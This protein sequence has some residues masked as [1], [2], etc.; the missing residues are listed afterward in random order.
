MMKY[1]IVIESVHVMEMSTCRLHI[2]QPDV[3]VMSAMNMT[4][5]ESWFMGVLHIQ[6]TVSSRPEQMISRSMA[7]GLVSHKRMG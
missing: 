1:E 4:L 2:A 5:M 3:R 7:R 6:C